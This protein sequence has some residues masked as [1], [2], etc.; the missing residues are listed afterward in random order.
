MSGDACVSCAP[1]AS[2]GQPVRDLLKV[3]CSAHG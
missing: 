3:T 2:D 1:L